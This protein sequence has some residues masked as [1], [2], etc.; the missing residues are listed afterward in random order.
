VKNILLS[1]VV[2]MIAATSNSASAKEVQ[3]LKHV[4]ISFS[5]NDAKSRLPA[6]VEEKAVIEAQARHVAKDR[7]LDEAIENLF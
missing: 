4:V 2:L 7:S 5:E 1:A 3:K 6:S